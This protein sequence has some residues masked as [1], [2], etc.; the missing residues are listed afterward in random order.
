VEATQIRQLDT[1]AIVVG[2]SGA[3][4]DRVIQ[5]LE[6][7]RIHIVRLGSA[8]VAC[9][10][11]VAAMPQVIVL[12]HAISGAERDVLADRA[13]AVGAM[14]VDVDAKVE[15]EAFEE[16]INDIITTAIQRKL[17]R[18]EC[19]KNEALPAPGA[20]ATE[21]IDGDWD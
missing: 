18:D 16:L 5:A 14:L 20:L 19:E 13:T 2:P 6:Q 9:E 8:A 15:G 12:L 11:V 10:R 7:A 17:S 4:A 1:T 21:E 3:N